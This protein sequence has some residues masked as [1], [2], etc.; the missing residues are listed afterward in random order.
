M[1]GDYPETNANCGIARWQ[2]PASKAWMMPKDLEDKEE[3]TEEEKERAL[4]NEVD[5]PATEQN[6]AHYI[7]YVHQLQNLYFALVGEELTIK[8][9]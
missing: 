1:I 7:K 6:T 3:L 4:N 8:E 9:K 5:I 2:Y